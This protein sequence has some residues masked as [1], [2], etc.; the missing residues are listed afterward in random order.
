MSNSNYKQLSETELRK[1]IKSHPQD[2][3]AFQ[4]YLSIIRKKP[5]SVVVSTDE[6]LKAELRK[7][8]NS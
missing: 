8:L 4:Y 3:D 7:R 2:E 5:N 6:Q 1:Y